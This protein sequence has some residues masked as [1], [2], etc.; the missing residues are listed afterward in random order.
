MA[1]GPLE[2]PIAGAARRERGDAAANR[3][4]VLRAARR[5]LA[6]HGPEGLTMDAV[7]AAAGVGKGTVFRR[8]GDRS[9][10]AAALVDDRMRDL[11]DRFLHGPPPLGPGAPPSERLDAFFAAFVDHV[12]GDLAA[13][14]LAE[15][16]R[17]GEDAG[18]YGAL[19]V[20]VATLIAA[21]DPDVDATVTAELLLSAVGPLLL[22]PGERP[23]PDVVLASLRALLRG[24]G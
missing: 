9:G 12:H 4:R 16:L 2:L 13:A 21:I 22:G 19:V 5:L 23:A 11:Q 6:E 10:L 17:R 1:D 8:F 7:A 20:H 3:A 24:L 14:H 15:E 18:A